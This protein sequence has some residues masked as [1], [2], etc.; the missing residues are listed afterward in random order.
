MTNTMTSRAF[1][2][3]VG[4]VINLWPAATHLKRQHIRSSSN[5]EA[6]T[7]DWKAIKDDIDKVFGDFQRATKSL[8]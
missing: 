8:K 4:S 2:R 3:G 5:N 6:L 7:K 1:L